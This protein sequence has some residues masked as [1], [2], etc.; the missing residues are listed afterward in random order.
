MD[1]D[2]SFSDKASQM[3]ENTLFHLNDK[4]SDS[5][6][7]FRIRSDVHIVIETHI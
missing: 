4:I 7:F 1:I 2:F 3:F 6:S 5:G